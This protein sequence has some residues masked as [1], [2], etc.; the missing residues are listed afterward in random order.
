MVL[1]EESKK[2]HKYT[3][4]P[5]LISVC[6]AGSDTVILPEG[7]VNNL[8]RFLDKGDEM[9]LNS[10]DISEELESDEDIKEAF[11]K[12][13]GLLVNRKSNWEILARDRARMDEALRL[14]C[15][16]EEGVNEAKVLMIKNM[17]SQKASE[18]LFLM[19]LG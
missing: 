8:F 18:S 3:E 4:F 19:L 16:R 2:G 7:E 5:K 11:I 17:R 6:L 12:Y 15:A 14:E 13:R 9:S 1:S 10:K